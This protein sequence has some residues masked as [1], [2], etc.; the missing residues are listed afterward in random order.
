M[1]PEHLHAIDT[2]IRAVNSRT[3]SPAAHGTGWRFWHD[4]SNNVVPVKNSLLEK[5]K[6]A[7][8]TQYFVK[9]RPTPL[10]VDTWQ[11]AWSEGTSRLDLEF[12]ATF[13][14]HVSNDQQAQNLVRALHS[15]EGIG[16][17]LYS[18]I[19]KYLHTHLMQ[20]LAECEAEQQDLLSVFHRSNIGAGESQSLNS[21][22][23]DG[24]S[25]ELGNTHFRIGLRIENVPPKQI[26]IE[27]PTEFT[28]ADTDG[29][30]SVKT[31][32]LLKLVS[33]QTYKR[34]GA[35]SEA[36]IEQTIKQAINE[37]VERYMFGIQYHTLFEIRAQQNH[38]LLESMRKYTQ[39][40]AEQ[41]GYELDIFQ[42]FPD[43]KA[44]MLLEEQ[45]IDID[46]AMHAFTPYLSTG[47]VRLKLSIGITAQD[48]RLL[49]HI[50]KPHEDNVLSKI[51]DEIVQACS[52]CIQR[53]NRR[54]FHLEFEPLVAPKLTQAISQCLEKYGLTGKIIT[55]SHAP[56]EEIERY[57]L[58]LGRSIDYRVEI[59]PQA[60]EGH[61][62]KVPISGRLEVTDMAENG[63]ECFER[64]DF[65]FNADSIWADH[66]SSPSTN[67][68]KPSNTLISAE[69]SRKQNAITK[70][71]VAI[72]TAAENIIFARLSK[73]VEL[74]QLTRSVEG[75]VEL[76]SVITKLIKD[77]IKAE[78]GLVVSVYG[79][80]RA[81][82]KAEQAAI[83]KHEKASD[84]AN[85]L[86]THET[87][88]TMDTINAIHAG[89]RSRV[90]HILKQLEA[91]ADDPEAEDERA[92]LQK[93]LAQ[94]QENLEKPATLA[95]EAKQLLKA[96]PRPEPS[97][98]RSISDALGTQDKKSSSDSS[99]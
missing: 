31:K 48:Y 61:G 20:Q 1:N 13:E 50:A 52:D 3:F 66:L 76:E 40:Y 71:L 88:H 26:P 59:S 91:I 65:G 95:T 44:L 21:T 89:E 38:P 42:T 72:R 45:R 60:S 55:L 11:F 97:S 53:I 39:T 30:R 69:K 15:V 7:N 86:T 27:H 98:I 35:P 79:T 24:V 93:Q 94:L 18:L 56:T 81:D 75:T 9:E 23:S 80:V 14:M 22:V 12:A 33:Y 57:T 87:S 63:W 73:L 67:D 51:E 90:D 43:I 36:Q 84:L 10:V 41:L 8:R 16:Q 85:N 78:F 62:F 25:R 46:P 37:A 49:S 92:T 2:L 96:K 70:E 82:T 6:G 17:R 54:E 32:A 34:A 64:K 47:Q 29:L 5:L 77:A 19:E 28:I 68:E 58:L 4:G 99:P 74:D 83:E